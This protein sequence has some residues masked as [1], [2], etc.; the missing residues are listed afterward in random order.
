MEGG[1][2]EERRGEERFWLVDKSF[3][4]FSSLFS[5]S[6]NFHF[7]NNHVSPGQQNRIGMT[8]FVSLGL[9]KPHTSSACE[10]CT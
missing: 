7:Q 10:E 5:T 3:S 1:R 8:G 4:V 2:G 6:R 9:N